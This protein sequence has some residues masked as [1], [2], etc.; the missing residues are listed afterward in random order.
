MSRK[1]VNQERERGRRVEQVLGMARRGLGVQNRQARCL[2]PSA[3]PRTEGIG[4]VL[5]VLVGDV[6]GV[7][8]VPGL[9]GRVGF[10][11]TCRV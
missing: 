6:S 9:R 7:G 5:G 3:A 2:C 10:K 11:E 4:D 1:L 8:D